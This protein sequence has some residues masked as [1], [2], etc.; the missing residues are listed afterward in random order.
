MLM[1]EN[2]LRSD[3]SIQYLNNRSYGQNLSST[4]G[5]TF[6]AQKFFKNSRFKLQVTTS[7]KTGVFMGIHAEMTKLEIIN[8]PETV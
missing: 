1:D 2:E 4:S 5:Q 3:R 8:I 6:V 7:Q